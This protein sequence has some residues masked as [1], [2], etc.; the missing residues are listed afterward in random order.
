MTTIS[1]QPG[2]I[3]LL[4][5]SGTPR[6]LAATSGEQVKLWCLLAGQREAKREQFTGDLRWPGSF[7][8]YEGAITAL[9]GIRAG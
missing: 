4:D 5:S 9:A 3:I 2:E 6:V 8:T 1:S 7:G